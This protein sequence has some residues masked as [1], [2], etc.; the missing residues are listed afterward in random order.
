MT[1]GASFLSGAGSTPVAR[2]S[3]DHQRPPCSRGGLPVAAD[4]K[5][6][7][8]Q[9]ARHPPLRWAGLSEESDAVK[10][11]VSEE[12][13]KISI[14]LDGKLIPCTAEELKQQ[15]QTLCLEAVE[16]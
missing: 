10:V 16:G 4:R 11:L 15:R 12:T 1:I 5:P 8:V 6:R 2:Q 9:V 3:R 13:G 7:I 14:V